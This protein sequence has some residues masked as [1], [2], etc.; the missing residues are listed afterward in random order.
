MQ[1]QVA[2]RLEEIFAAAKIHSPSDALKLVDVGDVTEENV[3]AKGRAIVADLRR[4]KAYLFDYGRVDFSDTS[5]SIQDLTSEVASD[6]QTRDR[7]AI[8]AR[9]P[10]PDFNDMSRSVDEITADF[11]SRHYV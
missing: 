4:S 1:S 10:E 6:L 8:R 9:T 2:K 7:F 5:R 11:L 3:E